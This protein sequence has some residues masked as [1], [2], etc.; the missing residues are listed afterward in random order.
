MR[1]FSLYSAVKGK[2]LLELYYIRSRQMYY[3]TL[4]SA[5][6]STLSDIYTDKFKPSSTKKCMTTVKSLE[7]GEPVNVNFVGPQFDTIS[8]KRVYNINYS[9]RTDDGL[10]LGD[11]EFGLCSRDNKTEIIPGH[12][13][14]Y[15]NDELAGVQIRL[16]QAAI[17]LA[18][19]F[20]IRNIPLDSLIPAVKFHTMMGFRPIKSFSTKVKSVED[21][22]NKVQNGFK[23]LQKDYA[24]SDIVPVLSKNKDDY[25]IDFNRTLYC[26][27]MKK[28]EKILKEK[29]LRHL[30]EDTSHLSY[31]VNMIL[32]STEINTWL[33]RIRGFEILPEHASD[34][35]SGFFAK[36][37]RFLFNLEK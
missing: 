30:P 32:P 21:V 17:E 23:T 7:T 9:L 15:K 13:H 8:K 22:Y 31:V 12:I 36:T 6:S 24:P 4:D 25:Y 35:K 14:S 19:K 3:E 33:N 28:N 11:K 29:G 37:A 5:K 26:T 20:N 10:L 2:D 16:L 1:V 34:D 18:H 27:A